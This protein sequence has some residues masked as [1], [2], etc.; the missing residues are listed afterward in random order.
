MR[1][2]ILID[3][4]HE[5]DWRQVVTPIRGIP[6]TS[7]RKEAWIEWAVRE[8]ERLS[9]PITTEDATHTTKAALIAA[10]GHPDPIPTAWTCTYCDLTAEMPTHQP[11]KQSKH[12]Q[13]D[14]CLLDQLEAAVTTGIGQGEVRAQK[15]TQVQLDVAALQLVEE[16]GDRLRAWLLDIGGRP[17]RMSLRELCRSWYAI[18]LASPDHEDEHARVL[19]GF[20]ARIRE[21]LDPRKPGYLEG[22]CPRC[23]FAY[24]I[25][26]DDIRK[27]ALQTR[28][29]ATYESTEAECQVCGAKWEGWSAL[30]E[31]ANGIARHADSERLESPPLTA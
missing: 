2:A 12:T 26:D 19:R 17:G 28:E 30:N 3:D 22:V 24:V 31:L 6:S 11:V 1:R 9:A 23:R 4:E 13:T 7:D 25:T 18:Q 29:G 10:Y 8:S 21:H 14:D 5:H 20:A 16:I 15:H 27:H